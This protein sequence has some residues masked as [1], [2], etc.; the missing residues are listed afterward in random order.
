MNMTKE[1][2]KDNSVIYQTY[3]RH[4]PVETRISYVRDI[5]DIYKTYD[6]A[7]HMSVVSQNMSGISH[8]RP[9]S[10]DIP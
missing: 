7:F 1:T 10:R 3:S 8:S 6:M 4:M 5:P 2:R 9:Y